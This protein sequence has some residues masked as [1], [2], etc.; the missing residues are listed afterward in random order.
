MKVG[1]L[2][3]SGSGKTTVFNLLTG[4]SADVGPGGG[5]TPNLGVIKVPDERLDKLS[6][7]YK[8]KKI[9]HAE[10]SFV[11]VAGRASDGSGAGLD[12]ALLT[13]IRDTDALTLVVRAFDSMLVAG[14]PKPAAELDALESEMI[15]ADLEVVDKRVERLRKENKLTSDE[16]RLL[17]RCKEHLEAEHPLRILEFTEAEQQILRGFRFLSKKPAIALLNTGDGQSMEPPPEL[18]QFATDHSI[19]IM[20]LC[21]AIEAEVAE[22][23]EEERE[24]FL[25]EYGIT[26]PAKDRF[27]R[28]AFAKLDLISFLTAG[29]KEVRAWPIQRGTSAVRAAGKIH[30]DIERGFIRVEIMPYDILI[31]L[32]SEAAVK[33]AG[34]MQVEGKEYVVKDGDVCLYRF[35]V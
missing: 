6:I 35:N 11:D 29:P 30:T 13:H 25:E 4:L 18:T 9:T 28:A 3:F 5:R 26:E 33:S 21:A 23:D 1:I 14:A 20:S 15:L 24:M 34:K 27:I 2:G 22:L 12:K 16:G 19:D 10:M 7:Q 17:A 32:G 31:N 8:P